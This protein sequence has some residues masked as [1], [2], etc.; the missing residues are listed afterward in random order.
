MEVLVLAQAVVDMAKAKNFAMFTTLRPDGHPASQ[1]M[2]VDCDDDFVLLNTEI[3]RRKYGN[4]LADPR[5]TVTIWQHDVPYKYVEIRGLVHDYIHGQPARDHI[6]QLAVKYFGRLYDSDQ[7]QS[8]RVIIRIRP[9][10]HR[11]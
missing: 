11:C 10:N 8:E 9:L 7:I 5:V 2:W 3:H 1:V 6:D 4:T